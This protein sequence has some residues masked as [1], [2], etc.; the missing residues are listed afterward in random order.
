MIKFQVVPGVGLWKLNPMNHAL[1][2]DYLENLL[3][4][5]FTILPY[6]YQGFGRVDVIEGFVNKSSITDK[7]FAT[8][9]MTGCCVTIERPTSDNA[10]LITVFKDVLERVVNNYTIVID[11]DRVYL[12]KDWSQMKTIERLE[13]EKLTLIYSC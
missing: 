1:R 13:G 12:L 2:N 3:E 7:R 11:N 6:L 10:E 8:M 9:K 4:L 5:S